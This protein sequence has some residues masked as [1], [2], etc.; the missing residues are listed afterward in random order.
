MT[1]Y[2]IEF[3]KQYL[4]DLKLARKRGLNE[5]LLN[6][7]IKML[8][9]GKDLP[10]RNKDHALRGNYAGFRECH[11]TPDWLLIYSKDA[12]VRIVKLVRAGSHAD[13]FGK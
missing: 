4:R 3:T 5:E 12:V 2:A 10:Q 1:S 9:A 6:E 13:L 11:I 8:M 7:I